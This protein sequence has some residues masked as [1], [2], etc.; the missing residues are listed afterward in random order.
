MKKDILV[1]CDE[2]TEYAWHMTDYIREKGEL[3]FEIHTYTEVEKLLMY[4]QGKEIEML[5]V[6]ESSYTYEVSELM[7]GQTL[8]LGESGEQKWNQIPYIDKY[9]QAEQIYKQIMEQYLEKMKSAG[10]REDKRESAKIIGL[11]SPIRRCLQTSFA[12]TLGQM[13]AWQHKTLYL[14]FEYYAGWSN[15]LKQEGYADL[16]DLLGLLEEPKEKFCYRLKILERKVGGLFYIAPV[17]SPQNLL[18]VNIFQWRL[19]LERIMQEGGY[20]YIILDLSEGIQGIFEILRMCDYVYT[21][22]RSDGMAQGKID[23]YE[24]LLRMYEYED[25]LH[26]TKKQLLPVFQNLP[27]QIEQYTKSELADYIKTVIYQDLQGGNC[28]GVY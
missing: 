19:L 4:G 16:S 21:L 13:L 14:S 8:I 6:A 26:K 11:Y 9:Q 17:Y 20:E 3:P 28:E 15:F 27:L 2:E 24:Q 10:G 12:L 25:V 1:L 23:Q 22:T 18:L 7:V 5:V